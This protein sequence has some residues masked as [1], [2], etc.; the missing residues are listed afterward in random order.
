M[1]D[2]VVMWGPDGAVLEANA[3][4]TRLIGPELDLEA[5]IADTREAEDYRYVV[6]DRRELSIHTT[7]LDAGRLTI[8]RDITAE[9]SLARRRREMQRLVSHELKTPLASIAGFGETLQRY[10]LSAEE[11]GRV[12]SLIRAEARRLQDMVT[13]FLDLE[14]LGA[15]HWDDDAES[16]DFGKLVAA[17]LE[18]LRAAAEARG[19][20]LIASIEGECPVRGVPVLLERVVDNLIGNAVKYS[21]DGDRIEVS[22]RRSDTKIV[23]AVRDHGPGIPD[24]SLAHL[25]DRFYRVPGSP[26]AGAG[27]GLAL[28][29]EAVDWHGGCI[30]IQS[31]VGVGSAF[32]VN[33]PTH[34]ED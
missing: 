20:E 25:F 28:A 5:V 33:L 16:I 1:E 6:R 27:L 7:D 18:V 29:K 26:S 10:D 34:P 4:A 21:G 2:G 30:D 13:V 22:V 24:A 8:I 23:F 17:R 12:A 19:Q 9:R 11:L 3:A 32:I 14:K 31:E 15:G